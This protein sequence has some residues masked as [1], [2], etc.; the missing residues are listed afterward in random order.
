MSIFNFVFTLLIHIYPSG[1]WREFFIN[2]PWHI[3]KMTYHRFNH[4]YELLNGY[5][6]A[7]IR[8]VIH[9]PDLMDI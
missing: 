7:N 3:L 9:P 6:V 5:F 1:D 4:L 2:N 8:Q